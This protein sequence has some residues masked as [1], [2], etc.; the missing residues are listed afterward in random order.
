MKIKFNKSQ[1]V[2]AGR[3]THIW[4]RNSIITLS[5][6]SAIRVEQHHCRLQI[7]LWLALLVKNGRSAAMS[8]WELRW[9]HSLWPQL[10][11][12]G[13]VAYGGVRKDKLPG[14][15][16]FSGKQQIGLE[17]KWIWCFGLVA[18]SVTR[19]LSLHLPRTQAPHIYS[20]LSLWH[21]KNF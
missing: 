12:P 9:A 1:Q 4:Y 17:S 3:T 15:I 16:W 7:S 10:T 18:P 19:C 11:H 5:Q 2:P 6:T 20:R 8:Q 21:C 13:D 14:F